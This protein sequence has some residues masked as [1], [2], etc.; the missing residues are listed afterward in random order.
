MHISNDTLF[1][2]GVGSFTLSVSQ[3]GNESFNP[4]TSDTTIVVKLAT[5]LPSEFAEEAFK[6]YPNP[7]TGRYILPL[8]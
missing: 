2:D 1:F 8:L 7:T 3:E 4:A 5:S 6:Y